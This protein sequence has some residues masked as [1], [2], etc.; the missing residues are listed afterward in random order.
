MSEQS[1]SIWEEIAD[2]LFDLHPAVFYALL[3]AVS[4]AVLL[5]EIGGSSS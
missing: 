2:W 3:G 4:V 1:E 5:V